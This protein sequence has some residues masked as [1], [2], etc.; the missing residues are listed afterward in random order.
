MMAKSE[1][2][3]F[4]VKCLKKTI[5][6]KIGKTCGVEWGK[7]EFNPLKFGNVI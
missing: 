1:G 6:Q 7:I 2:D 4:I 5:S 3:I